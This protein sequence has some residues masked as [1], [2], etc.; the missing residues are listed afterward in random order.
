MRGHGR[1]NLEGRRVGISMYSA[2]VILERS[3]FFIL[4]L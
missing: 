2:R 1:D 4:E 3:Y